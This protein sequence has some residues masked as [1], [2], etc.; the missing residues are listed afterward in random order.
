MCQNYNLPFGFDV[1]GSNEL[2]GDKITCSVGL[3]MFF[4][5]H[6][7]VI[8]LFTV[9]LWVCIISLN[10]PHI[11]YFIDMS[12]TDLKTLLTGIEHFDAAL[13]WITSIHIRSN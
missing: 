2:L 12:P 4:T 1:K 3:K 13:M 8:C 9:L 11:I 10:H 5:K 7:F 6:I